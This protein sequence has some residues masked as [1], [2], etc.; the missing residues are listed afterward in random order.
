MGVINA[1]LLRDAAPEEVD[2]VVVDVERG[3]TTQ[4]ADR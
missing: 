3:G 1:S 4:N 2:D